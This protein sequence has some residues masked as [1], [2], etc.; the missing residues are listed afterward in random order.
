MENLLTSVLHEEIDRHGRISFARFMEIALYFPELGYYRQETHE[1]FGTHGDFYTA[2]QL[3]PV[4]GELLASFVQRLYR[5]SGDPAEFAVLDLGAGRQDIREAL[6]PWGYRAFDWNTEPLPEKFSGVVI[7]NEFFDALPVHLLRKQKS[8]WCELMVEVMDDKFV[9]WEQGEISAP[10]ANYAEHYGSAAEEGQLMEVCLAAV[11]WM[12]RIGALLVSGDVLIIDYGYDA[13]ELCR[14]PEGTLVGFKRH[15]V[16][17]D[18]LS[19]PGTRDITAQVNF[20]YLR[21]LAIGAGME[22]LRD[23]S[24]AQWA[25]DVWGEDELSK[26]WKESDDRW[27]MLWK[28]LIFGMGSTFRVLHL[29]KGNVGG[30]VATK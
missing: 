20:S 26:R 5:A 17:R 18:F 4:W 27:R 23:S 9:F 11:E 21:D 13:R 3:Q 28:H 14:Y 10:L 8:G 25:I 7:A 19:E 22:V 29:R 15:A 6:R 24:L 16:A 30:G 2:G 12:D 1:V